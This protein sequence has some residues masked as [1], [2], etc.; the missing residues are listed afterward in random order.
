MLII[1]IIIIFVE[2]EGKRELQIVCEALSPFDEP[3]LVP[4]LTAPVP[5]SSES[6]PR[7]SFQRIRLNQHNQIPPLLP[8]PPPVS[9][10]SPSLMISS[11]SSLTMQNNPQSSNRQALYKQSASPFVLPDEFIPLTM[12]ESPGPNYPRLAGR[13]PSRSLPPGPAA[14]IA[15][16]PQP[17]RQ[18]F[19]RI[20]PP[21]HGSWRI[22]PKNSILA[23]NVHGGIE[24][25]RVR[26]LNNPLRVSNTLPLP[27]V[28]P[29]VHNSLA[30]R[31]PIGA[32]DED[33][34]HKPNALDN[35][36]DPGI[37]N[38]DRSSFYGTRLSSA[39]DDDN[40]VL[41][42]ES[43]TRNSDHF[44][45]I[46]TRSM[47]SSFVP[48]STTI[49]SVVPTPTIPLTY[50]T[51]YTYF[52][53]VQRGTHTAMLSREQIIS[54]THLE[55]IDRNIVTA[56]EHHQG[57]L[58]P[59]AS[60]M[61][62]GTKTKGATT[63]I[64]NVASRVQVFNDDL[65]KVIFATSTKSLPSSTMVTKL[66]P[67]PMTTP[68]SKH[69]VVSTKV[70][71]VVSPSI[72]SS[73][74]LSTPS[75]SIVNDERPIKSSIK[76]RLDQLQKQLM[77]QLS[78][79]TYYYTLIEGTQTQYSTR[80]EES[81]NN[82][83]G[84]LQT[85]V[86]S[87]APTIDAYGLLK[88]ISP[89]SIVPLGS[90]AHGESTTVVNL[91]LNNYI[92]F[93]QVKNAQID[94][95][96]FASV[97]RPSSPSP[98]STAILASSS[99]YIQPSEQ[100]EKFDFGTTSRIETPRLSSTKFVVSSTP[101]LSSSI[102]YETSE[103]PGRTI[104][105]TFSQPSS[106]SSSTARRPGIRIKL[107]PY[108]SKQLTR[109]SKIKQTV[110]STA[111]N[112][113]QINRSASSSSIDFASS[114]ILTPTI[115]D[116]TPVMFNS[117]TRQI[118]SPSDSYQL[119]SIEPGQRRKIV[120]NARHKPSSTSSSFSS[121]SQ[122]P[123]SASNLFDHQQPSINRFFSRR[124]TTSSRWLDDEPS[125]SP[126]FSPSSTM[127]WSRL[128]STTTSSSSLIP[129]ISSP[130]LPTSVPPDV[131]DARHRSPTPSLDDFVPRLTS[132]LF[133]SDQFASQATTSPSLSSSWQLSSSPLSPEEI[134]SSSKLNKN[135]LVKLTRLPG[136]AYNK[137][138]PMYN[139]R[140]RVSSRRLIKSTYPASMLSSMLMPIEP[141]VSSD[142]ESMIYTTTTHTVP[143]T[144][145]SSIIYTTIEE[146]NSQLLTPSL[147]P[148]THTSSSS[149]TREVDI[150]PSFVLEDR[151]QSSS[152]STSDSSS[153]SVQESTPQIPSADSYV[154][155]ETS[156]I[157]T[158]STLYSTYT[159]FATLFNG[160]RT[161]ITPLEEVKTEYLTLR[162]PITITRTIVPTVKITAS[163]PSDKTLEASTVSIDTF[164]F[165]E[166]NKSVEPDFETM[167]VTET[168]STQT[169]LTHF[170]T[171][172]SGSHTI[173]SSIEEI[174]PTVMTKT[175]Y[176]V[177]YTLSSQSSTVK[178]KQPS[179]TLSSQFSFATQST[180]SPTTTALIS[181]FTE[182]TTPEPTTTL[183][184]EISVSDDKKSDEESPNFFDPNR[185]V[186]S[187][188]SSSTSPSGIEPGSVI[189][190]EDL[191]EGVQDAG[192]I[193][194]TIKDIVKDI[195]TKPDPNDGDVIFSTQN[196]GHS[197][198]SASISTR[199]VTSVEKSIRTLTLT[200]TK[201]INNNNNTN[202]TKKQS[203]STTMNPTMTTTVKDHKS[204]RNKTSASMN[205][206][207]NSNNNNN[208]DHWNLC[209]PSCNITNK[210]YCREREPNRYVCECRPGYVRRP[211]DNLCQEIKNYLITVRVS[212]TAESEVIATST[213]TDGE[214]QKYARVA[215]RQVVGKADGIAGLQVLS[216]DHS[217]RSKGA[218]VNLTIQ[219]DP[220][221]LNL[222]DELAK[223]LE[224]LGHL[225]KVID[226]D[227]CSSSLHNDCSPR[228]R[229]LN[230]PGSYSCECLDP[231][232]DFDP[233]LPGRIC[234]TEL[235]SCDYCHGRGDCWR[236]QS[237]IVCRCHP[238][239]IGR[240]CEINGLFSTNEFVERDRFE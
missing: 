183:E 144:I 94:I 99:V 142:L 73:P 30:A 210:E 111:L 219:I 174:S 60:K 207:N 89:S 179:P 108:R 17:P 88:I 206:I 240:R 212:K 52:T 22:K 79:L 223:K 239:F 237:D 53:T 67:S 191:L 168:F 93:N 198:A 92:K 199:Y 33:L 165:D 8:P 90:R 46:R 178:S 163:K 35:E 113:D 186:E 63:T 195:F 106:S 96:P 23:S 1:I 13:G 236:N 4:I 139:S 177:P 226:F 152:E 166:E 127:K 112:E 203:T 32:Q 123:S 231:F 49:P 211:S 118:F 149:S 115:I 227:E 20:K 137:W 116:Q 181:S 54:S 150:S 78:L 48:R 97:E 110:V 95:K 7:P 75:S 117:A 188:S 119:E 170:I 215:R 136:A 141:T 213:T 205:N 47:E 57:Y 62:L 77:K 184:P 100:T 59:V 187:T 154:I 229:C 148:A 161:S 80:V 66:Q 38:R 160:T 159:Y 82:Y 24:P 12:T 14:P 120:Y 220:K 189:E 125:S 176:I 202:N 61:L 51:T 162:E 39:N 85:L 19:R 3:N 58:Q 98:S 190:L 173:L 134:I 104:S 157:M 37:I 31:G 15:G 196:D 146:T 140:V 232:I 101:S 42:L 175:K 201:S 209:Q 155:V 5:R 180:S 135:R 40:G 158:T 222:H 143:F 197:S 18:S 169:T 91:A 6:N 204:L 153:S 64:Y 71:D 68:T 233:S 147:S 114:L 200:S 21:Q 36:D 194:E 41:T 124:P 56:I 16:V 172:F 81:S 105:S 102:N 72:S 228:A 156:D 185:M 69:R 26:N 10:S 84:D 44:E 128:E 192:P 29:I 2:L 145:G 25:S 224:P 27:I 87:I 121:S 103:L 132:S 225:E 50:F 74:S 126:S 208:I 11:S 151:K 70:Q 171:L 107:K 109:H 235:K 164:D 65:Y 45:P 122:Y 238:M 28:D 76:I 138:S 43:L 217:L 55:P 216:V 218:L 129:T 86:P 214:L 193:G 133:G 230:E 130:S 182:W 9:A 131:S 34:I 167:M 234:V 221:A 83:N